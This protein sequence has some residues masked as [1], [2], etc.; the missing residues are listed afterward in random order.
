MQSIED[1]T[2]TWT[3]SYYG[4]KESIYENL[5]AIGLNDNQINLITLDEI[6]VKNDVKYKSF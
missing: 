5:I 3:A 2:I 4:E 1:K 6:K